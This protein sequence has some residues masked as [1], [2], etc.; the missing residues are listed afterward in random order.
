[1]ISTLMENWLLRL[2]SIVFAVVLWFFVTGEQRL[3]RSYL[4]PLELGNVPEGLMVANEVPSRIDVRI[5]GPR[6]LLI[7]IDQ[8]ELGIPVDLDGAK[9]GVVTFRRLEEQIDI[10]RGL[11]VTRVSPALVEVRLDRQRTRKVAVRAEV[12]GVPAE[13]YR[14]AAVAVA[15]ALAQVEGA[16]SELKNLKEVL[17]EPIAVEGLAESFVMTV[18]LIYQG[19]YS[20]LVEPSAVELEVKIEPIPASEKVKNRRSSK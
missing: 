15:P 10:P 13:G 17:T 11:K 1:M 20:R 12:T 14:V 3:E 18:P 8:G 5:S 2:L 19:D 7:N 9:P 4:V 6:T 16:E